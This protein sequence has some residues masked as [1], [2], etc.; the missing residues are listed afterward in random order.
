MTGCLRKIEKIN[1]CMKLV[2]IAFLVTD[3]NMGLCLYIYQLI[4]SSLQFGYVLIDRTPPYITKL[5]AQKQGLA[6]IFKW[7]ADNCGGSPMLGNQF[8]KCFFFFFLCWP[9]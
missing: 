5:E 4:V 3:E 8:S 7:A 6:C 9:S 2:K 1:I